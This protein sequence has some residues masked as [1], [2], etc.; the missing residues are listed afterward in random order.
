MIRSYLKL[1]ARVCGP[2]ALDREFGTVDF[3]MLLSVADMSRT[4][5]KRLGIEGVAA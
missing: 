5:L 3:F 1:G 4:Y 2:P